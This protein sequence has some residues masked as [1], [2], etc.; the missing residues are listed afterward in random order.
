MKAFNANRKPKYGRYDGIK[1]IIESN[2]V[3]DYGEFRATD[4]YIENYRDGANYGNPIS[5]YG[6]ERT[7]KA[8]FGSYR[9]L[10]RTHHEG[11]AFSLLKKY[12][13]ENDIFALIRLSDVQVVM[14]DRYVVLKKGGVFDVITGNWF[15]K[16]DFFKALSV[17]S[18]QKYVRGV[19]VFDYILFEIHAGET[20]DINN[21]YSVLNRK[22]EEEEEE[23]D[24][25]YCAYE[26][27]D[28]T[29]EEE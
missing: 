14:F 20:V 17:Y 3:D 1:A 6:V 22:V 26:V 2:I 13:D 29:E 8:Y 4:Y 16:K 12:T 24:A 28:N 25:L 10:W 9:A 18:N 5:E 23:E 21:I 19:A 15:K 7:I 27:D 11:R